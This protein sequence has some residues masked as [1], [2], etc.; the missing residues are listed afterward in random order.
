MRYYNE[1][2]EL[3]VIICESHGSIFDLTIEERSSAAMVTAALQESM[4]G[5]RVMAHI[6]KTQFDKYL[7]P[8]KHYKVVFVPKSVRFF[9]DEYDGSEVL[10]REDWVKWETA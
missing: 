6:A 1:K 4:T 9:I 3:G 8:H 7:N 10:I 5:N 2:G